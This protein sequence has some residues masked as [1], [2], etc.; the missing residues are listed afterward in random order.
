MLLRELNVVFEDEGYHQT[1]VEAFFNNPSLRIPATVE[2]TAVLD[3]AG[4]RYK[5]NSTFCLPNELGNVKVPYTPFQP[6][7]F[8]QTPMATRSQ[9]CQRLDRSNL[10]QGI[11]RSR[12][13]RNTCRLG[14]Q[15]DEAEY[16]RTIH[17][18]LREHREH[19]QAV[20]TA[21]WEDDGVLF[22]RRAGVF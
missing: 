15:S 7:D 18:T 2:R 6:L 8:G 5:G 12:I 9:T 11:P 16:T 22:K 13:Y 21:L 3:S 10:L 1:L 4:T 14:D 19:Q 20:L 17:R